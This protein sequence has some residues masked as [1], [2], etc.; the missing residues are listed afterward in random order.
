MGIG[1]V[2]LFDGVI[3]GENIGKMVVVELEVWGCD[4]DCLVVG[5]FCGGGCSKEGCCENSLDWW[6][7]FYDG[8]VMLLIWFDEEEK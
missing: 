2:K 7:E 4:E 5:V 1:D 3:Y 8:C 6:E